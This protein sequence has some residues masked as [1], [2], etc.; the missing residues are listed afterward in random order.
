MKTP[1]PVEFGIAIKVLRYTIS[2]YKDTNNVAWQINQIIS[3]LKN[4]I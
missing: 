1:T 2:I 3:L 4:L